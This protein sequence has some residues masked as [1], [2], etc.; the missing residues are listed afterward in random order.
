MEA[1]PQ[2]SAR[3]RRAKQIALFLDFDGTLVR[4]QRKPENVRLGDTEHRLLEGLARN[5]RVRLTFISG[6]RRADLKK[7]VGVSRAAYF[8]LHGFESRAKTFLSE[9]SRRSLDRIQ[10][11]VNPQIEGFPRVWLDDKQSSLAL[12]YRGA[13]NSLAAKG[14]AAVMRAVAG[15]SAPLHLLQGKKILEILPPEIEGKGAAVSKVLK[16]LGDG[17]LPVYFGD[18]ATDETAFAALRQLHRDGG[19]DPVTVHVGARSGTRAKYRVRNVDEVKV[20][21]ERLSQAL[22]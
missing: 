14:R 6:R 10:A 21:L 17:A 9:A 12:H 18:D 8:G 16:R 4:F 1:W 3:L 5:P 13:A 20:C 22:S 19:P 7:R 2:L 15:E 11:A